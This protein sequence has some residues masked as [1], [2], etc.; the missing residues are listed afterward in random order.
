MSSQ[1]M[2]K[3]GHNSVTKSPTEKKKIRVLLF[4]ILIPHIKFQDPISKH[5]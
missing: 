2:S 1:K 5:S 3:K 4:F